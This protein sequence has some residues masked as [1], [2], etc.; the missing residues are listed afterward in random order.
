M[1]QIKITNL[2]KYFLDKK[3]NTASAALH[4]INL[5]INSNELTLIT[6]PSGCGK[7]TLLKV[8]TGLSFPDS[9]LITFDNVDVTNLTADKRNLSFVS[10]KPILFPRMT[11]FNNLSLP[12]KLGKVNIEEI[13]R[14][15]YE[16]ANDLKFNDLLSRKP[17]VLSGG[18]IQLISIAKSL[19]KIPSILILDEPFTALNEE[20]K[21]MIMNYLLKIKKDFQMTVIIVTH[22]PETLI[23]YANQIIYLENGSVVKTIKR[24][25][26]DEK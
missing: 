11:I 3:E 14:R 24:E 23:K 4:D 15:V 22:K 19:I 5:I 10:E 1:A 17:K 16:I 8:I 12:L 21:E 25:I 13:R 7:T 2:Y 26:S 6:G 20:A 9:G 18:Q